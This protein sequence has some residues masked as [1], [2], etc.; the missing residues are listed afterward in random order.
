MSNRS[1]TGLSGAT[2]L[3]RVIVRFDVEDEPVAFAANAAL[4]CHDRVYDFFR[5]RD[6]DVP[7][8]AFDAGAL[9][10]DGCQG[11]GS[12]VEVGLSQTGT[13]PVGSYELYVELQTLDWFT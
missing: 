10:L 9:F 11:S 2:T 1:A 7:F 5:L 13:L 6:T 3:H 12:E 4:T 8:T